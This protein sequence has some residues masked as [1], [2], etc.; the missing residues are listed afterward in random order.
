MICM[1]D[2]FDWRFCFPS[3]QK[4][5]FR[6][7]IREMN[8]SYLKFIFCF[9]YAFCFFE[10][11]VHRVIWQQYMRHTVFSWNLWILG[12]R[13]SKNTEIGATHLLFDV[14][15]FEQKF[16]F[17]T[18]ILCCIVYYTYA[19]G[20]KNEKTFDVYKYTTIFYIE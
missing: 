1:I 6:W 16:S 15:L 20:A 11:L 4:A 12:K 9:L 5:I 7:I 17:E 8:S 18:Q 3:F 14:F 19:K 2:D 13:L 10:I